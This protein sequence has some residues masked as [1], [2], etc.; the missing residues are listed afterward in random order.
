MKRSEIIAITCMVIGLSS[1]NKEEIGIKT[2]EEIK[3]SA[4]YN[5]EVQT[6]ASVPFT[7]GYKATI[8]GYV[9]GTSP[10]SATPVAGTP[11]EATAGAGGALTPTNPV[12]LPKGSYD[13]YSVSQNNSTPAGLTFTTGLSQ[14]LTNQKDYLWAKHS[15]VSEGGVVTFGYNHKA[16]GVEINIS[17]GSGVSSMSVTSIKFTPT[18][19]DASSKLN[20]STGVI[21]AAADKDVLT[22]MSLSSSKGTYIMLPMVSKA[23]GIEVT[24]NATIG[25][26]AVTGKVYTGTIPERAYLSGTYYTIN[27]TISATSMSFTGSTVEDW[28]SQSI[29]GVTLTEQ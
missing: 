2:Y 29:S 12:Y 24:V 9:A 25:G 14:Q 13:F 15:S 4:S 17:A 10:S 16:V 26:T 20:L 28:T 27:L 22:S 3:F 21:A 11:Q 19:P 6:K 1:C 18:K 23:L 7:S 5:P 8:I